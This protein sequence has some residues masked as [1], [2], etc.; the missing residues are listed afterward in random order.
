MNPTAPVLP[1]S[2]PLPSVPPSDAVSQP[3]KTFSDLPA[4]GSKSPPKVSRAKIVVAL[5]TT[6]GIVAGLVAGFKQGTTAN[7]VCVKAAEGALGGALVGVA[8]AIL[9]LAKWI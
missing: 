4:S 5:L 9:R 3:M 7:M 1:V 2:S 6:T 8:L